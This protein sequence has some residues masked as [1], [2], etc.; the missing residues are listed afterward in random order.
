MAPLQVLEAAQKEVPR[1]GLAT[2]YRTLKSL[3]EE[4]LVTQVSLPGEVAHYEITNDRHHHHFHCRECGHVFEIETCPANLQM[5]TPRGF[6]VEDHDVVLYGRCPSCR[7][8]RS[9]RSR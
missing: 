8:G 9:R 2:V 7:N 4:G 3:V 1:L 6:A 5:L